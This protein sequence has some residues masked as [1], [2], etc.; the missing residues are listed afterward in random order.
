M[1]GIGGLDDSIIRNGHKYKLRAIYRDLVLAKSDMHYF[2]DAIMIKKEI[3]SLCS[4][5]G[6]GGITKK[7]YEIYTE[8][9]KNP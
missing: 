3:T 2:K 7:I 5:I 1:D 6:R 9:Q 8:V 4:V